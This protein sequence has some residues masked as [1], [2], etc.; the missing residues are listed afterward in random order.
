ME[1]Q[2]KIVGAF[3][4]VLALVHIGF[5]RHFKW[6]EDLKSISMINRQ[7]MY[8]H[9]FFIGFVV[10]LMGLL[11]LTSASELTGTM[12]GKRIA[13]GL[14]IFWT[15]RL[16]IQFFGYSSEVWKGR[17]FETGMHIL[18]SIFWAYVSVVFLLTY[19]S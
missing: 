1:V 4:I 2:L 18:F 13:L 11:C 8:V 16:V 15:A 17:T 10:F 6:K 14:G 19:F 7:I 5:P 3:F 12:L 9:S